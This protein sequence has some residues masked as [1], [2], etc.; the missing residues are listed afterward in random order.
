M[1]LSFLLS[2]LPISFFVYIYAR[3]CAITFSRSHIC[4]YQVTAATI[5]VW[6]ER[7]GV[8]AQL[9]RLPES[10]PT[11]V[12]YYYY[13]ARKLILILPPA[14]GRRLSRLSWLVTYRD[15]R[16]TWSS[17]VVH[18]ATVNR[19]LT[20]WL[21]A[22]CRLVSSDQIFIDS[23]RLVVMMSA[24]CG[25]RLRQSNSKRQPRRQTAADDRHQTYRRQRHCRPVHTVDSK[26]SRYRW[27]AIR[28]R[29][30]R[31]ETNVVLSRFNMFYFHKD[32]TLYLRALQMRV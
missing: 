5:H 23:R 8:A 19:R 7:R 30:A 2:P 22:G 1:H 14:V 9:C 16:A 25:E 31:A 20:D 17:I 24:R 32:M 4:Y 18:I 11:I 21:T 26:I 12:I 28:L 27:N 13:S 3:V 15:S 29:F 10:T 6:N